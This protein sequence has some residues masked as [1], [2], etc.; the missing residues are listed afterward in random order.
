[1]LAAIILAPIPM[2]DWH[3]WLYL[4][5]TVLKD[6]WT[7]EC[8]LL[9]MQYSY[10]PVLKL[11]MFGYPSEKTLPWQPS[12]HS[13]GTPDKNDKNVLEYNTNSPVPVILSSGPP[14]GHSP[15][16]YQRVTR[17]W[18]HQ[19][20]SCPLSKMTTESYIFHSHKLFIS[21]HL[22]SSPVTNHYC[23]TPFQ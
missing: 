18:R 13:C 10:T 6:S 14:L 9:Q 3:G 2:D 22:V 1:M 12:E 19:R 11:S 23:V 20:K 17:N 21:A 16:P 4:Y 5:H 8:G 7:H 15:I